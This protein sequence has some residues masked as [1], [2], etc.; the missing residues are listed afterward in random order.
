[1]QKDRNAAA[2]DTRKPIEPGAEAG[3]TID[4]GSVILV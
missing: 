1:M 3:L 2:I 4:P